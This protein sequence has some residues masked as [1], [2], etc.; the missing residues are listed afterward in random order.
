VFSI[1][2][3][4]TCLIGGGPSWLAP[5]TGPA[6]AASGPIAAPR[7]NASA[8]ATAQ[9]GRRDIRLTGDQI[10]RVT[11]HLHIAV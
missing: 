8:T 9:A 3:T 6:L 1:M 4:N 7:P 5:F 11:A 10:C 2:I